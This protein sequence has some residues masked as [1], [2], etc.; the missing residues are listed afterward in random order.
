M[1]KYARRGNLPVLVM[2]LGVILIVGALVGYIVLP[3]TGNQ[4]EMVSNQG[5]DT[6]AEIPR[7]ALEDAKTAYDSGEAMFIDVRG[8]DYYAASH[9]PGSRSIPLEKLESRLGELEPG[10]WII[11]Y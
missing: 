1:D 7:V 3:R 11:V 8:A 5:S 6:N 4:P 9:I 10:D 2:I